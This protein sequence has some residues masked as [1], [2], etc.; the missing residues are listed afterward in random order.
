MNPAPSFGPPAVLASSGVP[1]TSRARCESPGAS[2]KLNKEAFRH[3]NKERLV[4]RH[5]PKHFPFDSKTKA[6]FAYPLAGSP[7]ARFQLARLQSAGCRSSEAS[8]A[9]QNDT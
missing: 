7:S 8:Q 9:T 4:S 5:L 1:T 3:K 6:S 2:G